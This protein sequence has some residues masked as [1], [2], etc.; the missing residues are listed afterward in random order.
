[1]TRS[2][3]FS[4]VVRS[5]SRARRG[6]LVVHELTNLDP[7]GSAE[8]LIGLIVGRSV[9]GSVVRHRVSRRL[10]AQ[11][12]ERIDQIAAGAGVV[13]RALPESAGATSAQLGQDLDRAFDRLGHR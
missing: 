6:S 8:P 2:A 4:A 12:A 7:M 9:G 5:G 10:R 13:V 1:M 3:D 11:L